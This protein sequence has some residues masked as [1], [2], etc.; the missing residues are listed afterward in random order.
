MIIITITVIT[1]RQIDAADCSRFGRWTRDFLFAVLMPN[2]KITSIPYHNSLFLLLGRRRRDNN[3]KS[4]AHLLPSFHGHTQHNLQSTRPIGVTWFKRK[5]EGLFF[6][7]VAQLWIIFL[8][9]CCRR[10]WAFQIWCGVPDIVMI[11]S[12]EPGRGSSIVML[13]PE[14]PRIL[15]IL[16]PPLPIMAPA[17]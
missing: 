10:Y 17:N 14:S 16:A 3:V 9:L 2:N 6:I 12:D 4:L 11:R 15:R 7:M 13:A 1:K 8:Y 5:Y